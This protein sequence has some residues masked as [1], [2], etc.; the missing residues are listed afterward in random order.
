MRV[1]PSRF[2]MCWLAG[3]ALAALGSPAYAAALAFPEAQGFGAAATGGRGNRVVRVTTLADSG[4]GSLR[5][6]ISQGNRIVVFDVGGVI[7]LGSKLVAAGDNLTIA[8]QTAPGDGITVYG[9]GASFSSRKNIVVRFVRFHQGLGK[10]SAEGTKA[11]NLTDAQNM[12]FDHVS[13]QWGRWDSFGITGDSANVTL[14]DSIIGESIVPQKFGALVD[15]ADRVTLARNLW[16]DNESRNPKFKANGQYINNVVYNWGSGGGLVGGHSSADWYEDV[17]NNYFIAGPANTG[18][19]LSQYGS[20]DRVFHQGNLVDTD[21]DGRLSGRAVE[22]GDFKGD[23]PPTFE[24]VAHNRPGVPVP[25]LTAQAAYERVLAQA[26]VCSKRDAVDQ[27]LLGQ[28]RSLGTSGAIVGGDD[29]EAAVGGQP[30]A[31]ETRRPAGFDSDGDGMPDAWETAHGL[32]P[33]SAADAT[34]DG[35]GDGY[36][37]VE[38]YLNELAAGACGGSPSQPDAGMPADA[39]GDLARP[40]SRDSEPAADD[41]GTPPG[42]DARAD[43]D[44]AVPDADLGKRDATDGASFGPDGPDALAPAADARPDGPGDVPPDAEASRPDAAVPPDAAG[45]TGPEAGPDAATAAQGKDAGSA[46]SK[47]TSGCACTL[48]STRAPGG[49]PWLLLGLVV[50]LARRRRRAT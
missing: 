44:V 24:T 18:S 37:N 11:V 45:V 26:G 25:L 33:A 46:V 6:A 27:R 30:A 7:T 48:G 43:A 32:D 3:C 39:R 35:T 38:K 13:V 12:I 17:I 21:R 22:S 40:D 41:A 31:P 10:A 8:G 4:A 47:G 5:E 29:G 16:I 19:F 49:L 42:Q 23:S 36:T 15:S 50:G 20:T 1:F 14:Q 34:L 28:V 9:N 2:T